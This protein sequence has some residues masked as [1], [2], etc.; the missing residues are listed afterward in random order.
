MHAKVAQLCKKVLSGGHKFSARANACNQPYTT[1]MIQVCTRMAFARHS[2]YSEPEKDTIAIG[3]L[4]VHN[5]S[6]HTYMHTE[7]RATN[8]TV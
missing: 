8:D 4:N 3:A 6:L 7:Q 5:I 2:A 1:I